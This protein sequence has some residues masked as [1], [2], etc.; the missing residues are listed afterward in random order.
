[1]RSQPFEYYIA[2]HKKDDYKCPEVKGEG[3][4]FPK[5]YAV[6]ECITI[7]LGYIVYGIDFKNKV[8]A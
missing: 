8:K 6:D 4:F 3:R 5:T 2:K 7:T 1:M